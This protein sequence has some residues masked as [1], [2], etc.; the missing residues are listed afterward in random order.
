MFV[1]KEL[2]PPPLSKMRFLIAGK[3]KVGKST[4]MASIPGVAILDFE[5][6]Y[7]GLSVDK[8]LHCTDWSDLPKILD[9]I[10]SDKTT[11]TVVIDNLGSALSM[12]HRD[13]EKKSGKWKGDETGAKGWLIPREDIEN[14]CYRI[15]E[16]GKGLILISHLDDDQ[17]ESRG[18][19]IIKLRTTL[20]QKLENTLAGW[21]DFV[22]L[23]TQDEQGKR[24]IQ[25][26]GNDDVLGGSRFEQCFPSKIPMESQK[27]GK[28]VR[29]DQIEDLFESNFKKYMKEKSDGAE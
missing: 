16:S 11:D 5:N 24:W 2:S 8:Y 3:R 13:R 21:V 28:P 23:M 4:L 19:K 18:E 17:T 26:T 10:C 6:G 25:T 14:L 22:W 15:N 9:F 7:E 12:S 29:W 27:T 1:K 20:P